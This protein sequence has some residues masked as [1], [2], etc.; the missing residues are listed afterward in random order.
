MLDIGA[1]LGHDA[2]AADQESVL[3]RALSVGV[4]CIATGTSL[5][6]V[7]RI[8]SLGIPFT[9]GLHPHNARH[10]PS[11]H[12]E[13]VRRMDHPL[14]VAIGETGLD[15][16]RMASPREDQWRAFQWHVDQAI[17]H[18]KPLFLHV[19]DRTDDNSAFRDAYAMLKTHPNAR[20]IVHCFTGTTEQAIA[21]QS[22]GLH[23]G[24]TGWVL[25][26]R[27]S[28]LRATL[29]TG[30]V[31]LNRVHLETDAPYLLPSGLP[32]TGLSKYQGR[33]RNEPSMLPYIQDAVA[34]AMNVSR[35]TLADATMKNAQTLFGLRNSMTY[36]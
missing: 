6:A 20:G 32:R 26:E 33:W 29:Q 36:G 15:Y 17:A 10:W 3:A 11:E 21:W 34:S 16:D 28:A 5:D 22:L 18:G 25:Q 4:H 7:R 2:F 19:R 9:V 1:N 35:A 12:P 13:L 30:S 24:I 8:E 14:C 23:L 31:A 27:G